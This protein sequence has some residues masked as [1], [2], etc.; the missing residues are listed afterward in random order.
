MATRTKADLRTEIDAML[1]NNTTGLITP[2]IDRA[3][4]HDFIDSLLD[5]AAVVGG[6]GITVDQGADFV[7]VATEGPA[8][9]AQGIPSYLATNVVQA[10]DDQL[11]ADV[12]GLT[13]APP[14]PSV[15]FVFMPTTLN[16]AGVDVSLSINGGTPRALRDTRSA[17]V[18]ARRITPGGLYALLT[19][20]AVATSY[21][22]TEVLEVRPQD[23]DI[24]AAWSTDDDTLSASEIASGATSLTRTIFPP[25][26]PG[27]E[28]S[29]WQFFGVPDNVGDINSL[30]Q[31]G[32]FDNIFAYARVA[33]TIDY[34]GEPYK[35]WRSTSRR[36]GSSTGWIIG[37]AEPT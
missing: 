15:V 27:G 30:Q 36:R 14:S 5:R 31:V 4:R 23:F 25:D 10:S 37:L 1:A 9:A 35:W 16:R 26:V 32:G 19:R 24:V 22:F 29:G 11:T 13:G 17:T 3:L 21:Y 2:E 6:A 18:Q 28:E 8:A 34:N 12:I 7:T 20:T 33:G